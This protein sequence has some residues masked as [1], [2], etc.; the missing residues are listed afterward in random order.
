[1]TNVN[2]RRETYR[3][4]WPCDSAGKDGSD[5][6]TSQGVPESPE[7]GKNQVASSFLETLEGAWP[8]QYL[9]STLLAPKQ[10]ESKFVW[11]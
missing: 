6:T 3:A 4:K 7:A 11:V 8:C 9:A 1:M 5:A 10:R 2:I